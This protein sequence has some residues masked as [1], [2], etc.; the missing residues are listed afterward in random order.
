MN[1]WMRENIRFYY[2]GNIIFPENLVL[3][4]PNSMTFEWKFLGFFS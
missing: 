2:L 3:W 1:K 4:E